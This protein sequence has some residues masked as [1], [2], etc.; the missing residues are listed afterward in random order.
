MSNLRPLHLANCIFE[1]LQ[2]SDAAV[3][4]IAKSHNSPMQFT[5]VHSNYMRRIG[6]VNTEDVGAMQALSD[7]KPTL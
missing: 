5:H 4:A 7:T 1:D 3:L 2:R 6:N